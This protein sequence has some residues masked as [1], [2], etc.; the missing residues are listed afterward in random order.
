MRVPVLDKVKEARKATIESK[1]DILGVRGPVWNET[2]ALNPGKHHGKFSHNLL[3]NTLTPELINS[4]DVRK[5]TGTTAARGDPA[6]ATLDRSLSPAA[7]GPS[8]WN[9]STTLPSSNDRQRQLEA[10]LN[11]SLAA[12]ARR[13]AS[14]TPHYVDPVAR[15]TAY[16][17][18]IRAIKANSGADMGELTARYGP[19]GAEAMAAILAMP[20]KESR[21]R[22]RTTRADLQAVAALDAFSAGRDDAEEEEQGEAVP[23]SSPMPGAER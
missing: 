11:A 20:A 2:V 8:G 18:T 22:I 14:P 21:P 4:T 12:T 17:E 9:T 5:L 13:R 10:G 16:S 6:A 15:Q 7:G 19:D 3:S 23:L 1:P